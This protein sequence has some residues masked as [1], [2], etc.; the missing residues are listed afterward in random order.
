MLIH[1]AP[2]PQTVGCGSQER[3]AGQH[4]GDFAGSIKQAV[5]P[6]RSAPVQRFLACPANPFR[7]PMTKES[8]DFSQEA[9]QE[10]HKIYK[11]TGR[12]RLV[13]F[14][15]FAALPSN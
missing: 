5:H 4:E 15:F 11:T 9:P 1:A 6:D 12:S 10:N 13:A 2:H 8:P 7:D 14:T 3:L